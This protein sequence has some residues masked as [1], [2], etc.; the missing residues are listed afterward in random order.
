MPLGRKLIGS[1][2]FYIFLLA[3]VVMASSYFVYLRTLQPPTLLVPANVIV[4]TPPATTLV[5]TP[6]AENIAA[7]SAA[8]VAT[9]THSAPNAVPS[10]PTGKITEEG[11]I[12]G[13]AIPP[14]V[15]QNAGSIATPTAE[16]LAPT[17]TAITAA[18]E[19]QQKIR[20]VAHF[21]EVPTASVPTLF[22]GAG[23]PSASGFLPNYNQRMSGQLRTTDSRPRV[24]A[25]VEKNLDTL[26]S[27]VRFDQILSE[28]TG[29]FV[30]T[31]ITTVTQ[32]QATIEF[33][34]QF[35][36]TNAQGAALTQPCD[37]TFTVPNLAAAY[38]STVLPSGITLRADELE[39][40]RTH[41]VFRIFHSEGFT[42]NASELFV[43]F[44][45]LGLDKTTL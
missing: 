3:V 33:H 38:C 4:Q 28:N 31:S 44:E 2:G 36:S 35:K 21:V 30:T 18:T 11:A 27:V 25:S 1:G 22:T 10:R 43:F 16:H 19:P 40:S 8:P 5:I 20:V 13:Q 41:P 34:I 7:P 39:N 12:Q 42:S 9:S 14:T 45:V 15:S 24:L 23:E 26:N 37:G 6:T 29:I 17:G 32:A